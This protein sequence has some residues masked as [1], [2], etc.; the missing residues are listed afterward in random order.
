MVKIKNVDN[1]NCP[2]ECGQTRIL[3]FCWWEYKIAKSLWKKSVS[4]LN[5]N[6]HL[7]YDPANFSLGIRPREK[8]YPQKDLYTYVHIRFIIHSSQTLETTQVVI[9]EKMDKLWYIHI[10]EYCSVKKKK[11]KHEVTWM[12]SV[13]P[14]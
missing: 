14:C 5:L 9:N 6:I 13:T 3:A 12:K 1:N 4:F 10:Q 2:K 11:S 7:L 8:K